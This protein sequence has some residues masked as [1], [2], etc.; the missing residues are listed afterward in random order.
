[1][2][3]E[4][5]TPVETVTMQAPAVTVPSGVSTATR[6]PG[7]WVR[8]ACTGV[9]RRTTG[10]ASSRRRTKSPRPPSTFRSVPVSTLRCQSRVL[11][12]SASAPAITGPS[13]SST[14]SAQGS[15][16]MRR[17]TSAN[18]VSPRSARSEVATAS[19]RGQA[20]A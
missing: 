6:P 18:G 17:A 16:G 7:P 20:A 12:T 4:A 11:S 9:F 15:S 19:K 10:P 1:M 2:A 3:P 13:Q 5:S 8:T 14:D